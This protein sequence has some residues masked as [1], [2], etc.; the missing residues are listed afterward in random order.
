MFLLSFKQKEEDEQISEEKSI[1]L[2]WNACAAI[3]SSNIEIVNKIWKASIR[4][5]RICFKN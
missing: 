3:Y 2:A 5:I 4:V 1:E